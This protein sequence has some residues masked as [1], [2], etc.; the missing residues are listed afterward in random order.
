MVLDLLIG[1]DG[2]FLQVRIK[3]SSG[4]SRL[5]RAARQTLKRLDHAGPL[6]AVLKRDHWRIE[7]P[8]HY[9]LRR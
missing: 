3:Q 5:D 9:F 6:P 4:S 2:R 8:I 1:A 7:V